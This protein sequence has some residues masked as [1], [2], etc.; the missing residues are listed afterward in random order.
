M[1]PAFFVPEVSPL[2]NPYVCNMMHAYNKIGNVIVSDTTCTFQIRVQMC[3]IGTKQKQFRPTCN[4]FQRCICST[5]SE[6]GTKS[7]FAYVYN[8]C[9]I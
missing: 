2:H 3:E 1:A 7:L 8:M 5:L 6:S 9:N 4:F